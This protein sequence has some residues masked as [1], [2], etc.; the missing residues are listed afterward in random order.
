MPKVTIR[1]TKQS[2][3]YKRIAVTGAGGVAAT[4]VS[5][6]S[7]ATYIRR[8]ADKAP[9]ARFLL[10]APTIPAGSDIA[11][12]VPGARLKQ[13]TSRAPKLVTLAM[14][15]P[16]SGKPR[17]K[18]AP[19]V[20]GPVVRA[21]SGTSPY[22]YSTP[23]GAGATAGPAGPWAGLLSVLAVRVNDGHKAADANRATIYE[24]F[25]D[26]YY[27]ARPSAS[28]AISPASPVTTTSYPELTATLTALVE[29][30]Q[31]GSGAAARS[32]VEYELRVFSAAQYAIGGFDP[33]TSPCTWETQGLTAPLDYADGVTP[34]SEAASDVPDDPFVNG[35]YRAY[36]RGRRC[37]AA[38]AF[39]AWAS[40]DFA[41]N[42]PPPNPPTVSA[43]RGDAEQRVTVT[44]T[45]VATAGASSPLVS[46]ERSADGGATWTRVRGGLR[47]AG[48]F[49]SPL[50]VQDYEAERGRALAYRA[51]VEAT[52]SDQQLVSSWTMAAVSGVLPAAGWNLKVP[53]DP[54]QNLLG[55]NVIADPEWTQVEDAVTFRPVGRRHPVVVSMS[56]G[57]ADGSLAVVTGTDEEWEAVQALREYQGTLYLESPFGWGRYVRILSRSWSERGA[58]GAPSRR[59]EFGFLEVEMP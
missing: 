34:S 32:E 30:W 14:S 57:G 43:V 17:N 3:N 9:L 11:T 1:P 28:L 52:V 36:A 26:V 8:K 24:V 55:A 7:D 29:S 4:A 48:A 54:S 6:E 35:A 5:D 25:A 10:A 37:L 41:V 40:L 27:C 15:V 59:V 51:S 33:A 44:V 58:A 16:G 39:G 12:I 2:P 53:L 31:D 46:I 56:L 23:A 22:T 21:G 47:A 20:N 49:G 38:A 18:I 45:P 19:T 50:T 42:V 13:P